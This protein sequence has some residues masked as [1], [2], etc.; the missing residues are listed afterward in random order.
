MRIRNIVL[1]VLPV[2]SAF[3]VLRFLNQIDVFKPHSPHHHES[4]RRVPID[5]PSED[6]VQFGDFVVGG[7]AD[8]LSMFYRHLEAD[9]AKE[10]FLYSF[11]LKSNT[12]KKL[13]IKGFPENLKLNPHG[14]NLF[15]NKTLYFINHGF[16]HGG[17]NVILVDLEYNNGEITASYVKKVYVGPEI[18]IY[19][20]IYV[21]NNQYFY[22]TQ[23]LPDSL[24]EKGK[25]LSFLSEIKT[26]LKSF[27]IKSNSIRLCL[28]L[29]DQAICSPRAYGYMPNGIAKVKNQLLIAD[30]ITNS[31]DIYSISDAFE[32]SLVETVKFTHSLDNIRI[33]D[34]T[35]YVSG[36]ERGFEF[37]L[38]GEE[39]KKGSAG[40][41]V[42]GGVSKMFKKSGKWVS[43][44]IM[45]QNQLSLPSVAL[46]LSKNL[47]LGSFADPALL[48]CPLN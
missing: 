46:P 17:D 31:I 39:A 8:F 38:F 14:L 45:M 30:S 12:L 29:V 9:N 47:I 34:D 1:I 26:T 27:F 11:H 22:L 48:I 19:N 16:S 44:E 42:P 36:I 40:R 35:V 43:E 5:L 3:L 25:D 21:I 32:L 23:F 24:D 6:F 10:G 2:L 18:G 7:A 41:M 13:R 15:N 33:A 20:S 37:L 28:V 4:C